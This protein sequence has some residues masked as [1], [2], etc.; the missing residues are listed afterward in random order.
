MDEP[1]GPAGA[2]GPARRAPVRRALAWWMLGS[3]PWRHTA[4][5]AVVFALAVTV[6]L[7]VPVGGPTALRLIACTVAG[8]AFTAGFG[9]VSAARSRGEALVSPRAFRRWQRQVHAAH[10]ASTPHGGAR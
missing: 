6:S 3:A 10:R 7:L 5:S 4:L 8:L 9:V 2:P 1:H